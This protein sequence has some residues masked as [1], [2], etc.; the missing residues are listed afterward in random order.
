MLA[1]PSVRFRSAADDV[2]SLIRCHVKRIPLGQ[3]GDDAARGI[4]LVGDTELPRMLAA[5]AAERI[6]SL[7]FSGRLIAQFASG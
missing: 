4:N 6:S 5:A 3:A 7:A 1:R 2:A